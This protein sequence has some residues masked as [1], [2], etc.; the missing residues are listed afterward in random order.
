MHIADCTVGK[1][2]WKQN[3]AF[4]NDV[5]KEIGYRLDI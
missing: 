2:N 4:G 3:L 1:V 5:E